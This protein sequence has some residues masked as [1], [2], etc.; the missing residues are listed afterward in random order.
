MVWRRCVGEDLKKKKACLTCFCDS[1]RSH[2]GK[3]KKKKSI[4]IHIKEESSQ[5]RVSSQPGIREGF[6]VQLV[7]GI[8]KKKK[9][10]FL[11]DESQ[12]K[13]PSRRI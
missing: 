2:F 8:K 13:H 1:L 3:K 6:K 9:K 4:R 11:F 7:F 10:S 12:P 5:R